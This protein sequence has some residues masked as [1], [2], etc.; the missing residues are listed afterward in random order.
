MTR[1]VVTRRAKQDFDDI[2]Q[3]LTQRGGARVALRYAEKFRKQLITIVDFGS[4]TRRPQLGRNVRFTVTSPY[5]LIY[6]CEHD[7]VTLMRILDG[8][9]RI[10]RK[11]VAEGRD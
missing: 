7:A 10:T 11:L 6:H 4:G 8:R 3:Y 5:L 1:L 9:R 2:D